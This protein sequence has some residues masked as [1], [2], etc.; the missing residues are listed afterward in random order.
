MMLCMEFASLVCV[1]IK[2]GL[3]GGTDLPSLQE[4]YSFDI[5]LSLAA[6]ADL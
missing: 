5:H 6:N 4:T 2:I 3:K 1:A